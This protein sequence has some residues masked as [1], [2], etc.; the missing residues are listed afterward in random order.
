LAV[1][2]PLVTDVPSRF[3]DVEIEGEGGIIS[4]MPH[5]DFSLEAN[6]QASLGS[7]LRGSSTVPWMDVSFTIS[8][9]SA[10]GACHA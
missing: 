2:D 4:A 7:G 5:L 10:N 8:A 1:D 9:Q 3:F 6:S